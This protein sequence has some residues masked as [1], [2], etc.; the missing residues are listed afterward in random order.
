MAIRSLTALNVAVNAGTLALQS[1]ASTGGNHPARMTN[2]NLGP[3]GA[4]TGTLDLNDNDLVVNSGVFSAI[5]QMVFD[6]YSAA[7]N[8]AKTGIVSTTSQ[9]GGGNTILLLFDNALVGATE[10]PAGSGQSIGA[11]AVVGKYTYF[12][13]TNLDGQVTGDDYGA[14]DANLGRTGLNPG[15]AVLAGDTNFDN[16]VTGDDYAAVDSNL[17]LGVANP[18]AAASATS[19]PEP[20]AVFGAL[21]LAGT[22]WGARR[23]RVVTVRQ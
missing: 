1:R 15:I 19:V 13:D 12:G 14:I 23:R 16:Q 22:L 3:L 11:N 4:E 2:L 10:W 5:Q 21:G 8:T 17:G 6:G 18:L 9:A 7:P 20:S